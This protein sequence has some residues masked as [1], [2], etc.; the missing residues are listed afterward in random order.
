[1]VYQKKKYQKQN[2]KKERRENLKKKHEEDAEELFYSVLEEVRN[3]K[4]AIVVLTI[5][6]VLVFI[7]LVNANQKVSERGEIVLFVS[8]QLELCE[9]KLN[10]PK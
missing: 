2:R 8:K 3:L 4:N 1:L 6:L 5:V 10:M 7:N 9:E